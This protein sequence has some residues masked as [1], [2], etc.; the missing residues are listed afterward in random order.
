MAKRL[1]QGLRELPGVAISREV[2]TNAVFAR[3]P[4]AWIEPLRKTAPF[5]I[6]DPKTSEVRLMASWDTRPADV[7]AF[8]AAARALS[9]A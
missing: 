6:W 2:R 3:L 1:E 7:D 4:A 9:R 5:H 8:V